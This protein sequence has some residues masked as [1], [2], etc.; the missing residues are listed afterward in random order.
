MMPP[1]AADVCGVTHS[2]LCHGGNNAF[3]SVKPSIRR[4]PLVN[5]TCKHYSHPMMFTHG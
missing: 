1:S 3:H 5:A 4:P 2:K